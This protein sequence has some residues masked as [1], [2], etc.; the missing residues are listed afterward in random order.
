MLSDFFLFTYSS[1]WSKLQ[2]LSWKR[3]YLSAMSFI[4]FIFLYSSFRILIFSMTKLTFSIVIGHFSSRR[5]A[6]SIVSALRIAV[7]RKN[8][9]HKWYFALCHL[10][11]WTNCGGITKRTSNFVTFFFYLTFIC[12]IS[13]P[14]SKKENKLLW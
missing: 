10:Q 13:F 4:F 8:V 11:I 1:A 9:S 6:E 7:L 14:I 5:N 3:Q 12:A 2:L